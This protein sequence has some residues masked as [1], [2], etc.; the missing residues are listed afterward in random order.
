M[1]GRSVHLHPFTLTHTRERARHV[2]TA[3]TLTLTP[4]LTL[5]P[6]LTQE[7]A[8]HVRETHGR[9]THAA[10]EAEG[11]EKREGGSSLT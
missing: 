1:S 8:K 4:T 10:R 5:M 11:G 9:E 6:T 2:R 3:F 7:R